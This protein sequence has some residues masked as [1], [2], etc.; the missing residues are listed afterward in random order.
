MTQPIHMPSD[1][2]LKHLLEL[3]QQ[4]LPHVNDVSLE[5]MAWFTRNCAYF[6]AL[7]DDSGP[8]GFLGAMDPACD[9]SS[10]NFR[11]FKERYPSFIY[12]DRIVVSDRAR[13]MGVAT[14]LYSDLA[15]FALGMA[16][17]L[18]CEVNLR[19]ANPVSLRFHE[20]LGFREVGQQDTEGG[21]KTV[22]LMVKELGN[23]SSP[24]LDQT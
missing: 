1:Q 22:C 2:D 3:N 15:D 11:W 12:I 24:T 9:Y 20:S 16:P 21:K 5:E 23:G 14:R 7:S 8:L 18:A 10:L 17:L 4:A 13:R 19:P 6:R